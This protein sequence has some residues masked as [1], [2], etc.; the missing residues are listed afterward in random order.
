LA[1]AIK[2]AGGPPV[3]VNWLMRRRRTPS[4]GK[5]NAAGRRRNVA[6]AFAL[7]RGA[8]VAGKRILL[9]DDVFTTGATIE[10]C[11]RVLLRAGATRVDALTL[12]R[13]VRETA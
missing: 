10:E 1:H 9:V 7:H 13:V 12:A 11:A 2:A 4:Q 6:H 8:N 5:R 3:A